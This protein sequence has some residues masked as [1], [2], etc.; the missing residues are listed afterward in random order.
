MIWA[1]FCVDAETFPFTARCV[2]D[3]AT[4][5]APISCGWRLLSNKMNHLAQWMYCLSVVKL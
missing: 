5:A 2:G 4:S 1:W 3:A